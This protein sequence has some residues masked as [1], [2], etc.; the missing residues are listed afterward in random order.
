MLELGVGLC[1][2]DLSGRRALGS[3]EHPVT[4]AKRWVVIGIMRYTGP[5]LFKDAFDFVLLSPPLGGSGGGSGLS[6][7]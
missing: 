7:S 1:L 3:L 2:A 6:F 4:G 5:A